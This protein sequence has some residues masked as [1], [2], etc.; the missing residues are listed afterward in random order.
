MRRIQILYA[1]SKSPT[2]GLVIW[3]GVNIAN[4]YLGNEFAFVFQLAHKPRAL[5]LL[6]VLMIS[7][8]C[9]SP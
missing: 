3:G 7:W 6:I 2:L 5:L 8:N 1:L 4:E 9:C